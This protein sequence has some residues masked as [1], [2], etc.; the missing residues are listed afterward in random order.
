MGNGSGH[1]AIDNLI[2]ANTL[3]EIMRNKR[4]NWTDLLFKAQTKGG[5]DRYIH[6][7]VRGLPTQGLI[8]NQTNLLRMMLENNPAYADTTSLAEGKKRLANHP[9]IGSRLYKLLFGAEQ[10]PGSNDPAISN[11]LSKGR[12]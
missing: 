10:S 1:D 2:V 12:K 9:S 3:Q 6:S 5:E 7:G 8:E 11:F 4:D